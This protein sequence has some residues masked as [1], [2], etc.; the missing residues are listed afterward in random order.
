MHCKSVELS[1]CQWG[2]AARLSAAVVGFRTAAGNLWPICAAGLADGGVGGGRGTSNGNIKGKQRI[3]LLER[4]TANPRTGRRGHHRLR[5]KALWSARTR[6][7]GRRSACGRIR[8][9]QPRTG[10]LLLRSVQPP[11]QLL[12]ALITQSAL[13]L[14]LQQVH[15]GQLQPQE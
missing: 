1:R 14:I 4:R 7:G 9:A 10:L 8:G 15:R 11:V 6:H 12:G 3:I 13:N 2:T 5:L